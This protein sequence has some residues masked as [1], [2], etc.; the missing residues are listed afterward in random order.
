MLALILFLI[1]VY[2]YFTLDK[3]LKR[4]PSKNPIRTKKRLLF[5]I[6][7]LGSLAALE[8]FLNIRLERSLWNADFISPFFNGFEAWLTYELKPLLEI[9]MPRQEICRGISIE[10]I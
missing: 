7:A 8:L 4:Y 6:F 10:T 5:G 3:I 1:L 9:E 2:Q